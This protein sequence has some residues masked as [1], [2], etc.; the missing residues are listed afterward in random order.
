MVFPF[1]PDPSH[2][3][4]TAALSDLVAVL[5][6]LPELAQDAAL[7]SIREDCD[8]LAVEVRRGIEEFAIV[9]RK[10]LGGDVYAYEVDGYGSNYFMDDAN[11]PSLL[12]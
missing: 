6:S 2:S 7:K 4:L 12:S 10:D 1:S 8:S 5:D 3:Q 11:V 9:N